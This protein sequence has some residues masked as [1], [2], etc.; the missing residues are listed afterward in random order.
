MPP[1]TER[2][3]RSVRLLIGLAS[4]LTSSIACSEAEEEKQCEPENRHQTIVGEEDQTFHVGPYLEHT[5]GTSAAIG[6][7]TLEA[8]DTRLV[9]E[10][11]DERTIEGPAGTMHQVTINALQPG[12]TYRYRACTNEQCTRELTFSTAPD[13]GV[14]IRFA[15]Y[16]DCQDNPAAHRKVIDQVMADEANL[17]LVVGDTVSDGRNREEFKER[18]YDPARILSHSVPRYA[19]IGNHDRKDV[20]AEHYRDYHIFP[21]DPG[22]PPSQQE[23]S[24]SFTYGDAFFLVFDN[25]LDHLDLFFPIDG[26]ED[27]PLWRWLQEQ[28]KSPAA[29]NARWR[30]AFAHYPPDAECYGS[31]HDD[32]LP[33]SAMRT[34]VLP[35]LWEHGF[36]GYFAGHVHCYERLDFDGHLAIITGGGGGGLENTEEKCVRELPEAR[37]QACVHH[38]V[39]LELGCEH[40]EVWSRDFDGNIIDRVVLHEDGSYEPAP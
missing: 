39:T 4:A 28:V 1:R 32:G 11:P 13:S 34:S 36:Q 30:F 35:L 9:L 10:G 22:V 3:G 14:P 6:W 23:T 17:V 12:T 20:E 31:D 21:E 19:A 5:T 37:H 18:Y 16:G 38:H 25:T 24:Y 29:Q 26:V 15:V 33:G 40:A 8:G 7:E 2:A 27:P